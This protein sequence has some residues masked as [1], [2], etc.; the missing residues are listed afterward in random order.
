MEQQVG[1]LPVL[2]ERSSEQ[3]L[4]YGDDGLCS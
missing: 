2:D 1:S 4:G 3:I